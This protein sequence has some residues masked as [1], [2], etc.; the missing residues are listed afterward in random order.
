MIHMHANLMRPARRDVHP[1]KCV[2]LILPDDF[3]I[4]KGV[5]SALSRN[6]FLSAVKLPLNRD[7]NPA[8]SVFKYTACQCIIGLCVNPLF[9]LL[10]HVSR[11]GPAFGK[12]NKP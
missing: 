8:A 11:H 3:I 1:Q 10:S 4:S 2:I 6:P 9:S 7:F 5:I 12:Q